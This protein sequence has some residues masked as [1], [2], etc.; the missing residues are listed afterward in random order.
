[1]GYADEKIIEAINKSKLNKDINEG[2]I[3]INNNS[4]EFVDTYFFKDQISLKIPKE[5]IEM[6]MDIQDIKYPSVKRP[7]I[8]KTDDSNNINITLTHIKSGLTN[9]LV[10]ELLKSMEKIIRKQNPLNVIYDN[11]T[12]N[13]NEKNIGCLEFKNSAIDDFVYNLMFF[14]EFKKE[15]IMGNFVCPFNEHDVWKKVAVDVVKSV[16]V[17]EEE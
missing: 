14:F 6:P 10:G 17:K 16:R 3:V 9:E 8:I 11:K 7:Q 12:I 5:F 13:V 2:P 4:Y 1:M 15:T